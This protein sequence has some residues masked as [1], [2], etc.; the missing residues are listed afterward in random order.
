M[1]LD[2]VELVIEV[3][4]TFGITISDLEAEKTRTVGDLHAL[5]VRKLGE[6]EGLRARGE[7]ARPPRRFTR[8]GVGRW[9]PWASI[10]RRFILP[11][12]SPP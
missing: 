12:P 1:G 7:F 10:A 5:I 9:R 4:E 3:E 8:C 2:G 6:R 11:R